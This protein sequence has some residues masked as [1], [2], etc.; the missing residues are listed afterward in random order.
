MKKNLLLIPIAVLLLQLYSF[1]QACQPDPKYTTSGVFPDS[2]TGFDTATAGVAYTQLVTVVIPKDTNA[3][4]PFPP[5]S[6]DSTVLVSVA[7]L[8]SSMNYAC[9]NSSTKP[10]NCSW[11]GN[12]KGCAIITGTPTSAEVGTHP[13]TFNTN[14][15]IGGSAT[16]HAYVISY[17][18]I[19]VKA[20]TTDV[21]E[22]PGIQ[23]LL[24]NNPNPFG[25]KSEILFSAEDIGTAKFKIYNMIGTVVQQYDIKVKRGINKIELEG[26][27]FDSG[28]YFYSIVNGNNV[29]TRKMIV[30]K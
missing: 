20:S 27:D 5:L 8:P 25:D 21:N 13:L 7:G 30:K 14:N 24:Q 18:K 19:I 16:V 28:I 4:P 22:N 23:T 17:Y 1:G 6:W 29:F 10:N 12:T 11:K 26:K 15:Y 2:A 9:W 3:I